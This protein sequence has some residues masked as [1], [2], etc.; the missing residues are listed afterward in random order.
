MSDRYY[1][2]DA[3]TDRVKAETTSRKAHGNQ[4]QSEQVAAARTAEHNEYMYWMKLRG[5][6]SSSRDGRS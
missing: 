3:V 6:R 4:Q 5:R 1:H 2:P